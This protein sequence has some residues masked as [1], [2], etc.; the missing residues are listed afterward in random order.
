MSDGSGLDQGGS[1][2]KW[3]DSGYILEGQAVEF[4]DWLDVER[5]RDVKVFGLSNG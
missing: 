5:E 1:G 3:L 4:T 2:K